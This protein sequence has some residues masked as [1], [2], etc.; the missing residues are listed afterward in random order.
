MDNS[1]STG[2]DPEHPDIKKQKAKNKRRF[3]NGNE[4]MTWIKL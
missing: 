3:F 1:S 2:F 4:L